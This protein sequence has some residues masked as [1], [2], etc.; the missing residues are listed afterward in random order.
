MNISSLIIKV[1]CVAMLIAL[2]ACGSKQLVNDLKFVSSSSNPIPAGDT[3]SETKTIDI[4]HM[5]ILG[6]PLGTVA[7]PENAYGA[8]AKDSLY[9]NHLKLTPGGW[10]FGR[11]NNQPLIGRTCWTAEGTVVKEKK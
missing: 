7:A 11:I 4:C 6:I 2:A 1:A 3:T 8:L 10:S 9:V 5:S